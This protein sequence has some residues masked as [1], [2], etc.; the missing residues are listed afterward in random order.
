MRS[1]TEDSWLRCAPFESFRLPT[2]ADTPPRPSPRSSRWSNARFVYNAPPILYEKSRFRPRWAVRLVL[3]VPAVAAIITV[4]TTDN[5]NPA[6][7]PTPAGS[8]SG[9]TSSDGDEIRFNIFPAQALTTLSRL[10]WISADS[11]E[12][13]DD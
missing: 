4:T 11:E 10:Q 8:G 12:P 7:G 13:C 3:S 9:K 1:A 6:T 2:L 5:V